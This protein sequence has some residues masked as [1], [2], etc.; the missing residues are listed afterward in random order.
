MLGQCVVHALVQS[1]HIG[2]CVQVAVLP[3][4]HFVATQVKDV[5]K[6]CKFETWSSGNEGT[7]LQFKFKLEWIPV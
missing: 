4:T 3:G 6:T 5:Q 2:A 1:Y 7:V